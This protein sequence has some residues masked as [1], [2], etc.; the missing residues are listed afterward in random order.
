[1]ILFNI[2]CT[3]LLAYSANASFASTCDPLKST[4]EPDTA[5]G[6]SIYLDFKS[7]S[8]Y[9]SPYAC[10]SDISYS[11]KGL[12]TVWKTYGDSPS[13][14]SNFYIMYGKMEIKA[15]TS[16]GVGL[17]ST[18]FFQ[19]DDG[20][21][22]DFEWVSTFKNKVQ[23]NYFGKGI[24]GSYDRGT[25]VDLSFDTTADYH[26]YAI[27]WKEN[28]TIWSIDGKAVRTL[29]KS[30]VKNDGQHDYPQS[31][32]RIFLGLWAGGDPSNGA[33]T[34]QW[35]GGKTSTSGAPFY[36]N[37]E[38]I[39]V[40]DYSTGSEYSYADKT[41]NSIT[42]KN[43]KINGRPDAGFPGSV[44]KDQLLSV[45]S[46]STT[47]A[48]VSMTGFVNAT[49]TVEVSFIS[50]N[51]LSSSVTSG[52]ALSST[53]VA[54]AAVQADNSANASRSSETAF[55]SSN[56]SSSSS[57][58]SS[59]AVYGAS[60]LSDETSSVTDTS[61]IVASITTTLANGET[62]GVSYGVSTDANGSLDTYTTEYIPLTSTHTNLHFVTIKRSNKTDGI[63]FE[64]G[65]E[66]SF[67]TKLF[68]SFM[69]TV[70]AGIII[71]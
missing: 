60:D 64:G 6:K 26:T 11:D 17:I 3:L 23:T 12:Q 55:T 18:M 41:G 70:F 66:S 52:A 29:Q 2:L 25:T 51:T 38:Y 19:S 28:E 27:E 32:M 71:F 50:S 43:G 37:I 8:S 13:L 69:L 61:V 34:I 39:K 62:T 45:A 53:T 4:C 7:E 5:L 31:P 20:D 10:A 44:A 15:K 42:A 57:F 68:F 59:Y 36:Y 56:Y 1:M 9:F 40:S 46:K 65:A 63:S 16:L 58:S 24:T 21:E 49:Q 22:I 30:S 33:N 47:S 35:A 14:R 54:A 48:L 67:K